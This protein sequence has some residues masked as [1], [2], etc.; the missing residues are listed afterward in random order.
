MTK[1]KYAKFPNV[2]EGST[3]E[4]LDDRAVAW[5][6]RG[7]RVEV[8]LPL[9]GVTSVPE[10][11]NVN[12]DLR[13]L[14]RAGAR[15]RFVPGSW[16]RHTASSV[17]HVRA[18]IDDAVVVYRFWHGTRQRWAYD[19]D[20]VATMSALWESGHLKAVGDGNNDV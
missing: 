11:V 1:G 2:P 20:S 6:P 16:T 15:L 13:A 9:G 8:K 3:I 18:V 17:W 19:L 10:G 5:Y 14:L 4:Y 7:E 12:A